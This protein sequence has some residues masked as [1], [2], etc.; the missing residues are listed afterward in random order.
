M[1]CVFK[2]EE[3]GGEREPGSPSFLSV[4]GYCGPG[5]GQLGPTKMIETAHTT[6][7]RLAVSGKILTW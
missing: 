6:G 3:G 2:L 1:R 7:R 5:D 4:V